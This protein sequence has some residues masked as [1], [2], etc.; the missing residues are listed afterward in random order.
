MENLS[1]PAAQ[2]LCE[3]C[4]TFK[5]TSPPRLQFQCKVSFGSFLTDLKISEGTTFT[6][7][8]SCAEQTNFNKRKKSKNESCLFMCKSKKY[9]IMSPATYLFSSSLASHSCTL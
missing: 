1:P 7:I 2:L 4:A 5:L 6:G 8:S 3:P 9:F